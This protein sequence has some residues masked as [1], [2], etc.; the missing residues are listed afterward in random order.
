MLFPFQNFFYLLRDRGAAGGIG[1]L[2]CYLPGCHPMIESRKKT[3]IPKPDRI[4]EGSGR[5]GGSAPRRDVQTAL[6]GVFTC[7]D[8][9]GHCIPLQ[10]DGRAADILRF[11]GEICTKSTDLV[12]AIKNA[13][14]RQRIVARGHKY[15]SI[16]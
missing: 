1:I 11:R 15:G 3:R 4:A 10:R 8:K 9:G 7:R 14:R 6:C 2:L 16:V 5:C 12:L 13:S